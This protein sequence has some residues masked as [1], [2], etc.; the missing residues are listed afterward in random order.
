MADNIIPFPV[1]AH[2]DLPPEEQARL[3]EFQHAFDSIERVLDAMKVLPASSAFILGAVM[4]A[5][6]QPEKTEAL[7]QGIKDR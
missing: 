5:V 7:C 1:P 3:D 6:A 4:A 2:G